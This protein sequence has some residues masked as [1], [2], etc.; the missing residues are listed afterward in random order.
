MLLN[1]GAEG[2]SWR[3]PWTARRSNQSILKEIN[4]EYSLEGLMLKFQYFGDL[5]Q[6]ADSLE[7]ILM[8]E[9]LKEG[10]EGDDRGWDGGWQNRING[11]EFK[12]I[13]GDCERQ[14]PGMLQ[15]VGLQRVGHDWAIEQQQPKTQ[16]INENFTMWQL[17]LLYY[18]CY[19]HE[20]TCMLI[21][22]HTISLARDSISQVYSQNR[23]MQLLLLME[24]AQYR[25]RSPACELFG[26]GQITQ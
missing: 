26:K 9:R 24:L 3:V 16:L 5:V 21:Y 22:M 19:V 17:L 7:K 2:D 8:L 18:C 6:E 13:L 1:C 15:S 11:H 4:H 14:K 20:Y 23:R 12:Q 10:G 25:S